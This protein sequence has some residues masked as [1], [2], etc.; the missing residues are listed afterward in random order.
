MRDGRRCHSLSWRGPSDP[1]SPGKG[2]HDPR[3]GRA[4]RP[5]RGIGML[6]EL[7][8]A[9]SEQRQTGPALQLGWP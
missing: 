2:A 6:M 5:H 1:A 4:S 8:K 9:A 3:H 7:L